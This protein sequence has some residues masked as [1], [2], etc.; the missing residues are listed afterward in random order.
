MREK[1][2]DFF[3]KSNHQFISGEELS[4][5]LNISR[6]A[7]WKQIEELKKEGYQFEAIRRKGYRLLNNPDDISSDRIKDGLKTEWLGQHLVYLPETNSTQIAAHDLA[8]NGAD[9]GTVI[10]TNKQ[11]NG[12]GRL[13][14]SWYGEEGNGISMSIILRPDFHYQQAPLITLFTSL[15]IINAYNTLY[16]INA[17]IKWPNDIYLNDRKNAGIL[18]EMH[19]EQDQIHYLIIGIGINTKQS[20]YPTEI[21]E[22]AIS[23]EELLGQAPKRV[24]LIQEILH[25]FEQ[26]YGKFS[27]FGF[28]EFYPLYHNHLYKKGHMITVHQPTKQIT[29]YI[30]GIDENGYLILKQ[31]SGDLIK[32]VSGDIKFD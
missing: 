8:K 3:L 14:R 2:K 15:A 7:I 27:E 18:T 24:K 12:K 22:K 31:E 1:I 19:G 11:T 5:K 6:T 13:G 17:R 20:D 4:K 23:L 16:P 32:I 9:H 21:K 29:G 30:N 26:E 25:Q 28:Q 10:L